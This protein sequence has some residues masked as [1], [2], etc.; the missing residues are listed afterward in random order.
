MEAALDL[1]DRARQAKSAVYIIGNGG[2][3]AIASHVIT[4]FTNV[5]GLRARTLH[6]SS[7]ITCMAN[8]YGYENAFARLL[9]A[10]AVKDDV[11]IAISSSGRSK[12]ILNAADAMKTAGGRV[13]TLSGFDRDNPLRKTGD[14]NV[15]VDSH[16]YGLVEIGHLFLLHNL[17]DRFGAL[18]KSTAQ[19]NAKR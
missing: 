6:E 10:H 18:K 9:G 17:A 12:N 1:L 14:L 2:S 3:S 16:D 5:A 11:L 7:L 15:W 8:D 4:D 19:K 13:L